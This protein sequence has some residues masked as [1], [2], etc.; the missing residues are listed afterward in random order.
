MKKK[1][2]LFVIVLLVL[3]SLVYAGT[4]KVTSEH[5]FLINGEWIPAKELKIGDRLTE[6]NGKTV[7][8]TSIKKVTPKEPFLVYNI[9]A[10]KYH[11]FVVRDTDNLSIVV[12]N[13]NA[14]DYNNLLPTKPRRIF[15]VEQAKEIYQ[16]Y[17]KEGITLNNLGFAVRYDPKSQTSRYNR[18]VLLPKDVYLESIEEIPSAFHRPLYFVVNIM[19][20]KEIILFGLARQKHQLLISFSSSVK[21]LSVHQ[22]INKVYGELQKNIGTD[23]DCNFPTLR[24][25]LEVGGGVCRHKSSILNTMLRKAGIN[26][27]EISNFGHVWVRVNDP[28]LGTFDLDPTWYIGP[29]RLPVRTKLDVSNPFSYPSW[30]AEFLRLNSP[31][32]KK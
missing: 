6:I 2:L 11:N 32:F 28:V 7:E 4:L 21:D 30:E 20:Q 1:G 14:V 15:D 29:V 24:K 5:P 27:W 13:S 26:S 12:H 22:R 8:I 19:G 16:I 23:Y 9:E 17:E 31:S 10:G 18:V 25:S 3:S